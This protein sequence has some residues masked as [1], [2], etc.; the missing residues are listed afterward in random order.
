MPKPT[1][2]VDG[3]ERKLVA[4]GWCATHYMR[5][6][7]H[8]D[9]HANF[10]PKR[11]VRGVCIVDDCDLEDH[12]VHGYCNKHA[13]RVARHGDPSVNRRSTGR[14]TCNIEGCGKF[15][16]GHGL[17]PMHW[18]RNKKNGS[19]HIVKPVPAWDE[20]PQWRGDAATYDAVHWRLRRKKGRASERDCVDC[21]GQAQH[22][23]Y[24]GLD[25]KQ[26][27]QGVLAYSLNP[28]HY[29]PRCVPCHGAYDSAK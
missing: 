2:S 14:K 5:W 7:K 3:C 19:P 8:G 21:G 1:C 24:D 9:P 18:A 11:E 25:P 28:G 12:G 10:G 17:C 26:L 29:F 27:N 13:I 23:S 20:S 6:R 4:R 15:V 22:W 16:E